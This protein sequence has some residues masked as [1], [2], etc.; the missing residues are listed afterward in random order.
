MGQVGDA[1]LS[2]LWPGETENI[3]IG[4]LTER[5]CNLDYALQSVL[6]PTRDE[7]KEFRKTRDNA[8]SLDAWGAVITARASLA[9]RE[10]GLFPGP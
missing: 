8:D 7:V 10:A 6:A 1:R 2:E 3:P 4:A 5:F 9:G